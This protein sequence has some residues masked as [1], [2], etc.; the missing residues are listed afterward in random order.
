MLK[1]TLPDGSVRE[2]E[3]QQTVKQVALSIGPGLARA[4]VGGILCGH[5]DNGG[6][7]YVELSR[8]LSGEVSLKL[9][10]E[11]MEA[12]S[13]Y[14]IRH[15]CAHVMA[16]AVTRLFPQAHLAFGPPID[17]GFYYDFQIDHP[18]SPEDL[19]A[20]EAKMAEIVAEKLPFERE[21]LAPDEARQR[22]RDRGETLKLEA[23]EDL[24]ARGQEISFYRHGD[25]EDLC[26][27]GHLEQ[28]G[29]LKAFKLKSV[30]GAYWRGNSDGPQLQR[31]YGTAF[32]SK[33]A[34]KKHLALLEEAK[35]RD[36]RRI[37]PQLK[38]FV[39]REEAPAQPFYLPNGMRV[40]N[41]LFDY[42]RE[43]QEGL[44]YQE[45]RT[46]LMLSDELWRRSGHYDNYKENMYFLE[47][48]DKSIAVKPMNCPGC[49]LVYN[50]ELHSYRDLPL[51]L[52]EYGLCHR[53]EMTGVV[54]GLFRTR[55]F[56]QDD[57]HIFCLPEQIEDQVLETMALVDTLYRT[58]DFTYRIELSTRPEKSIG[59]EEIWATATTALHNALERSGLPYTVNE[60]DG[61]FYGPKID[62]HVTDSL[63]RSWQCGTIQCDFFMPGES[64]LNCSYVGS[65]GAH[66]VP[67]MIHRAIFGS[68]ERF[69]GILIEHYAGAFPTWLA[70]QQVR[71]LPITDAQGAYAQQIDKT[72]KA[73]GIRSEVDLRNE[74]IGFK[75]R[76]ATL[77]KVPYM[78]V[79]GKREEADGVVALR[80][81]KAGDKGTCLLDAFIARIGEEIS[82]RSS[83]ASETETL[84]E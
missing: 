28:T 38:L 29:Q 11:K 72:L 17:N 44:G 26:L 8:L 84:E 69:F 19:V 27:G 51:K 1:V 24:I 67:V 50:S 43:L 46:P 58:F 16:D 48:D 53:Q 36:H 52:A 3:Q 13:L 82:C 77:A 75:I 49:C 41:G 6:D 63:E 37:G 45:I 21:V 81:R 35:K 57:A 32:Y 22:L 9:V 23:L 25:F 30:A 73:A 62:F 56:T 60:G 4:A 2:Y 39:F 10:T 12:E 70:P 15:S 64:A 55:A 74:K 78:M 61:A 66:H 7:Q 31:I 34:L 76:E 14:F 18:F 71:V 65:D 20:I 80:E 40:I 68:I 79:V 42:S 59:S 33:K 83:V 47:I 54:H 5:L